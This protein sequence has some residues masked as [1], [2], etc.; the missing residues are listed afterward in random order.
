VKNKKLL[1]ILPAYNEEKTIYQIVKKLKKF[2]FVLVIDDYS[3]DK[4]KKKAIEA[5][6]KVISNKKNFGYE[7]SINI[8]I[9]FFLNKKYQ[10]LITMD[11]DGQHPIKYVPIFQTFLNKN[12]DVICGVR[13]LILRKSE[14]I[15]IFLSKIFLDLRDPLC[16]LKGYSRPFLIKYYSKKKSNY[17]S[18]EYLVIAKKKNLNIL[19]YEIET[20]PRKDISRF[21][22]SLMTDVKIL[23]TLVNIL[24][25]L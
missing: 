4:T 22:N 1:I 20:K 24:F 21:G 25:F 19:Q 12:Y 18:T 8:G 3:D 2:G 16:G 13:S 15:F 5:G 10:Y 6:A 17:I 11:A 7:N 14:K 9:K 23:I